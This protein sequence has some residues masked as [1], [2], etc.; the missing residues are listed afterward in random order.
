MSPF[1]EGILH[2]TDLQGYDHML[3]LVALSASFSWR[4]WKSLLLLATAFTLGHS[5]TLAIVSLD[6]VHINTGLIELL[7]PITIALTSLYNFFFGKKEISFSSYVIIVF[8]GL[9]HGMGFSSYFRMMFG[10][11]L[12]IIGN[13]FLFNAGVEVGQVLILVAI[14]LIYAL[15]DLLFNEERVRAKV[16]SAACFI[17]SVYLI[18]CIV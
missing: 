18:A 7:I 10:E 16:F 6:I 15:I 9:I 4:N 8:F 1:F 12:D 11:G 14:L 13:L 2:I 5:L 17:V 3:F